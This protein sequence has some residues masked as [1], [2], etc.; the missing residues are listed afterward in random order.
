VDDVSGGGAEEDTARI[1]VFELRPSNVSLNTA[2]WRT[3]FAELVAAPVADTD[4]GLFST[5]PALFLDQDDANIAR[6][7]LVVPAIELLSKEIAAIA[8]HHIARAMGIANGTEGLMSLPTLY[9]Q[10]SATVG[11]GF[12]EAERADLRTLAEPMLLPGK[13]HV[14]RMKPFQLNPAQPSVLTIL[15]GVVNQERLFYPTGGRPDRL[16]SDMRYEVY[17]NSTGPLGVSWPNN[18]QDGLMRASPPATVSGQW[19]TDAVYFRVIATDDVDGSYTAWNH[20][21]NVLIDT[22]SLSGTALGNALLINR[23]VMEGPAR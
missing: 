5:N 11:L 10:Y 20:R 21:V 16:P 6:Y 1:P 4:A 13:S 9:G 3:A 7:K 19:Y 14:L 2:T 23:Q 12:T 17:Y 18:A 8:A 22:S 15:G